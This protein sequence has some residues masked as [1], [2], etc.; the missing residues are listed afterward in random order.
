LAYIVPIVDHVLGVR[1]GATPLPEIR[2]IVVSP[3]DA[4]ANS[5]EEELRKFLNHSSPDGAG[6]V[7]FRRFTG[8]E[9]DEQR[10]EIREHPPDILLTTT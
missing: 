10:E 8:Q 2:A 1:E 7:T 4:L 5:Q 6:P 3:M 9:S